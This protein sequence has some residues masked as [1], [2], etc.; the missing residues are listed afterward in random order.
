MDAGNKIDKDDLLEMLNFLK[1]FADKCHHGKEEGFLFP[2]M[3]KA[4]I[5]RENGPIGQMLIEHAQGREFIKRMGLAIDMDNVDYKGYIAS[6][7]G[8]IELLRSHIVKEN[9]ILFPMADKMIPIE[10]QKE[11]LESF[12]D[13]EEEV[14]GKG[15]HEKLHETLHRFEKKYL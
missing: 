9:T 8:Y 11:M 6:A 2:A 13:Y 1:L 15:I 4:G 14:M 10:K 7:V 5:K 3:E 12:E